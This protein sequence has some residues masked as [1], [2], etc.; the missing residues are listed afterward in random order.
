MTKKITVLLQIS[1]PENWVDE[2]SDWLQKAYHS[3]FHPR[4]LQSVLYP[5]I[6]YSTHWYRVLEQ[7]SERADNTIRQNDTPCQ[8]ETVYSDT[9]NLLTWRHLTKLSNTTYV[10]RLHSK[11]P[12]I[13]ID[14]S[15]QSPSTASLRV[16]LRL[17]QR[18][19]LSYL[20][21]GR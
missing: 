9:L 11:D 13:S 19:K 3:S 4:H 5:I 7:Y 18:L 17:W 8:N 21:A 10:H 12:P 14:P 15:V 2:E 1:L 6:Q 16:W 20:L